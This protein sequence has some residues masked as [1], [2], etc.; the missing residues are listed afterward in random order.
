M[1]QFIQVSLCFLFSFGTAFAQ[2]T[3]PDLIMESVQ[4][5]SCDATS[6]SYAATIRNVG[7]VV[8]QLD[9]N[10]SV[11]SQNVSIQAYLRVNND[12]TTSGSDRPAGGTVISCSPSD[13][14]PGESVVKT[15]SATV[16]SGIDPSVT[17]YLEIYLIPERI[18]AFS[19]VNVDT[20]NSGF[21]PLPSKSTSGPDL[22]IES[23]EVLSCDA[24]GSISYAATIKNV[25]DAA[26]QL[27][28]NQG[29]CSQNVSIQAYLRVNNDGTT[30]GSDRPAGGT[31]ISCSPADLQP[32]ESVVKTFSATVSSG[33]DP[34]VTPYLEIYLI[35]E[36]IRAFSDVN[37]DTSN[38]GFTP[39]PSKSTSGP[40]LIIESVEVLSC[41]A[42]GSISY[43]ATIKNVG[44]AA[45]QL[46]NNQGVCSQNVSIQ[47]YL[48]VNNDGTTSG[49]DRPAGGTVISCSP[50]DLQPGESVVKTFSATVSSGIDPSVTP[51]LE[52]YLIPAR[53]TSFS[54]INIDP[55]NSGFT[56]LPSK[57]PD[58]SQLHE[59]EGGI[60]IANTECQT[61][62]S[63]R[64]NGMDFEGYLA[65]EWQSLTN[66][67]PGPQGD[68]GATGPTGATGATGVQGP[69]GTAALAYGV[70]NS[71]AK[72][73]NGSQNFSCTWNTTQ[74]WY[75]IDIAGENYFYADYVTAG[76]PLGYAASI[77]TSSVS[78][79]LIVMIYDTDGNRIQ[80]FF[81]FQ[82]IKI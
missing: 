19:D 60:K 82:T 34:S 1:K 71:N 7:D 78:G 79:N 3:G 62:G 36:R 64:F 10:Q 57:D 42:N 47:A 29:V 73:I 50:A 37:V 30:S 15:F 17:P 75:E 81:S 65:G 45:S 4:I 8:S 13:L 23:V 72:V 56:A 61:E 44:D 25:G 54:D 76:T 16:S 74:N 32:G 55:D 43:A 11:C 26:S 41:D 46:D 12:G 66:G 39:L 49:S 48:R 58:C 38:S 20:S 22:I 31:V 52:I 2:P 33:I 14:Q 80:G 68:T 18:R 21:T 77:A 59:V 51:Y 53:L 35:P 67:T 24:N 63:I 9:N 40:D 70:I 28:N 69:P 27:D 6:I 5:L